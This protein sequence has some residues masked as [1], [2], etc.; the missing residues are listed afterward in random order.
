[1]HISEKRLEREPLKDLDKSYILNFLHMVKRDGME[2]LIQLLCESDFFTA[3]AST[4]YHSNIEGGLAYHSINVYE[5]LGEKNKKFNLEI[6]AESVIIAG[7]LHDVCKINFYVKE[8][9]SVCV[10]KKQ[11]WKNEKN[12]NDEWIRVLKTV[13][14][15]QEKEVWEVKD[16]FPIGHGEK[17]IIMLMKYIDLTDLE[18]AMIRWHMLFT[19]PKEF[20]YIMQNCLKVYPAILALY[21]ADLEASYFLEETKE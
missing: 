11:E 15:W 5:L 6:P 20:H 19:E 4:K 18:I 3:P 12:E 8:S 13:N 14:D 21:S 17:S 9:K 1:M 2:D 16:P 10:C 7:L